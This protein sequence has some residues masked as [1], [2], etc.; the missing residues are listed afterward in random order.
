MVLTEVQK[1]LAQEGFHKRTSKEVED[2]ARAVDPQMMQKVKDLG[3]AT[4]TYG[5]CRAFYENVSQLVGQTSLYDLFTS[6]FY[7]FI[8]WRLDNLLE[9][10]NEHTRSVA[11][12]C[13]GTGL[14]AVFLAER[15]P[16]IT[17]SAI[18]FSPG[19]IQ[20]TNERVQRRGVTN[21]RS[22]V[23]NRDELPLLANSVDLMLCLHA[24]TEGDRNFYEHSGFA[25]IYANQIK[26]ARLSKF[27]ELISSGGKL[28]VSYPMLGE[29]SP[30]Y[31]E[32]YDD[33]MLGNLDFAGFS[34]VVKYAINGKDA[35]DTPSR[36]A[37][38]IATK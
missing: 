12:V 14:E 31:E 37:F 29:T 38:F 13:C 16:N 15:F 17:V 27:R 20:R 4:D 18:D 33:I 36:E 3:H 23:G 8:E 7:D 22:I 19:M 25:E 5:G 2:L 11:D 28:V 26:V 21:L 10:V 1:Y 30:T 35:D 9:V 6:R 34:N 32:Y 24:I